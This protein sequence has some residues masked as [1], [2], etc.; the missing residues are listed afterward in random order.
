MSRSNSFDQSK[1]YTFLG[2]DTDNYCRALRHSYPHC[3]KHLCRLHGFFRTSYPAEIS[4]GVSPFRSY[5]A[6]A[7]D[8]EM[9]DPWVGLLVE[10]PNN[11]RNNYFDGIQSKGVGRLHSE[12]EPSKRR[13]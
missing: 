5:W 2:L 13:V 3:S 10:C 4:D 7:Y 1:L 9:L 12:R 11:I 8:E 6:L